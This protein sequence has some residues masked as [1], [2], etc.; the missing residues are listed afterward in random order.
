MKIEGHSHL[1]GTP[2]VVWLL[3]TDPERLQKLLPGAESLVADG[4]H[5]VGGTT[6]DGGRR[7]RNHL[8]ILHFCRRRV[9]TPENL[10]AGSREFS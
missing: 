3:L 7:E 1:P 5:R 4:P 6:N 8:P 9:E 10:T 2:E